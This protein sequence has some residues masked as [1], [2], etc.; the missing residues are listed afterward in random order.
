MS[1]IKKLGQELSNLGYMRGVLETY[2]E[3][4]A[5][6]MQKVRGKIESGREFTSGLSELS[7]NIGMDVVAV[8][9]V[10]TVIPAYLLLGPNSGMFG[11]F[12]AQLVAGFAREIAGKEGDVYV[13]GEMAGKML[14][15]VIGGRNFRVLKLTNE[16]MDNQ[17][18]QMTVEQLR[19]YR[20]V[21]VV[22]GKF[23]NLAKQEVAMRDLAGE[24][25]LDFLAQKDKEIKM[26]RLK[27]LYEPSLDIVGAKLSREVF[28]SVMGASAE[29]SQLA[30]FA[31]RLMHLDQSLFNLD[32]IKLSLSHKKRRLG[33]KIENKK[34]GIRVV[35]RRVRL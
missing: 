13:V 30:K 12:S 24:M 5:S 32:K 4:A 21:R 2:E 35:A 33:R 7:Y 10:E 27:Y 15:K 26:R 14:G 9:G 22:Y 6:R 29:E 28:V 11:E 1:S 16:E 18:L 34:Q 20:T 31:A 23:V 3:M 19:N 17:L 8:A 25:T